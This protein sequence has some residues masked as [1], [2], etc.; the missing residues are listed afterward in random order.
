MKS[1]VEI[2]SVTL[3]GLYL[4]LKSYRSLII[5]ALMLAA[6]PIFNIF[7]LFYLISNRNGLTSIFQNEPFLFFIFVVTLGVYAT[8]MIYYILITKNESH[9]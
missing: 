5:P 3:D 6:L 9:S 2:F 7:L 8:G 4:Y 1:S